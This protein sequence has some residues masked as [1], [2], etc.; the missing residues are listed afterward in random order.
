MK[1]NIRK[2]QQKSMDFKIS[3]N[4]PVYGCTAYSLY[5]MNYSEKPSKHKLKCGNNIFWFPSR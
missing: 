1:H 4:N 5:Y 3:S 2:E